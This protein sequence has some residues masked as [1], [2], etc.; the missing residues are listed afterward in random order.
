[1]SPTSASTDVAAVAVLGALVPFLLLLLPFVAYAL[2]GFFVVQPQTQAVIL[3]FGK[4]LRT[5]SDAGIHYTFPLG[6]R[7][8]RVTSSVIAVDLPRVTVLEASGSPI[9]VSGICSYRVV[10]AQRALLDVADYGALVS[11][12]ATAV[13]K[14]VCAEYPYDAPDPHTPCLRKENDAVVAHLVRDLQALVA[15]AGVQVL[16]MRI[17]DLTYAPEIAQSML[18][19]QQAAAMVDSRRTI[20]EGAVRTAC[21]AQAQMRSS[22]MPVDPAASASFASSLMLVLCSG[23]RVQ[24]FMPVQVEV[25][26]HG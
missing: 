3:R 19:R 10:D 24:T 16:Q 26:G 18:L 1:M 20:V 2:G 12:L 7:I 15:P 9:E 8:L 21:D 6:R 14:N 25:S 22:G 5:V 17:N 11:L 23:E 13:M 4:P